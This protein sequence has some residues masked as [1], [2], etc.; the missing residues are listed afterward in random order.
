ML[1]IYDSSS[2]NMI[3]LP[4]IMGCLGAGHFPDSPVA[5]SAF[6][7]PLTFDISRYNIARYCT[8][9]DNLED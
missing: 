1:D 8:E 5:Q 4:G 2:E 9:Y 3:K 7:T 6:Q